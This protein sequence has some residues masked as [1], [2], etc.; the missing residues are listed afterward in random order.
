[1]EAYFI[2]TKSYVIWYENGHGPSV[3]VKFEIFGE[4]WCEF[5]VNFTKCGMEM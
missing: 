4:I 3:L 2:R 5:D 1:M